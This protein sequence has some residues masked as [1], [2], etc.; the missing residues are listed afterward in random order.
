M[1]LSDSATQQEELMREMSLRRAANHAPDLP[2]TGECHWCG[3]LVTEGHRFCD[4]DCRDMFDKAQKIA[5]I[6][7]RAT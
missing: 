5:A 4:P 7:G 3:A 6:T 2:A 1:D